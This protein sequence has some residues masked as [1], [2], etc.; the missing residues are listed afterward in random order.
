MEIQS[1]IDKTTVSKIK[2][3]CKETLGLV[4]IKMLASDNSKTTLKLIGFK[5]QQAQ[6]EIKKWFFNDI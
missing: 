1:K 2:D 6:T 3:Y 4:D 5:H